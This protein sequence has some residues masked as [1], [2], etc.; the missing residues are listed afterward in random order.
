[1][2]D[3]VK[4]S[5]LVGAGLTLL[6]ADKMKDFIETLIKEGGMTEQE[7]RETAKELMEKTESTK[8]T[9]D[10]KKKQIL[11]DASAFW[12]YGVLSD[13]IEEKLEHLVQT[14]LRQCRVPRR[15]DLEEL[16]IRI[17]RLEK[18]QTGQNP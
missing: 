10:D 6:T 2:L 5:I 12:L 1:M 14:E 17:E 8:N 9:L 11:N 4:K 18:E 13:D 16:R 7:A 15:S 3:L